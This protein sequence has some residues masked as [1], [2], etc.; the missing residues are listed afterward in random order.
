L[1]GTYIRRNFGFLVNPDSIL[2]HQKAILDNRGHLLEEARDI[3]E[4][5]KFIRTNKNILEHLKIY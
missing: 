2:E 3:L 4:N 5:R 1:K